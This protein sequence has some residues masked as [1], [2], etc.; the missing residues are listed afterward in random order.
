MGKIVSMSKAKQLYEILKQELES[1]KY[2]IGDRLP[3]IRSMAEEYGVSTNTV[4]TALSILVNNGLVYIEEGNGAYV[5]VER[6]AIRVLGTLL[7]DFS[8]GLRVDVDILKAIQDYTPDRYCLSLMNTGNRYDVFC[9]GLRQLA[10]M[11][12]AGYLIVPPRQEPTAEERAEA[13]RLISTR[14]TVMINRTIEGVEADTYSMN[15]CKG[16]EKAFA[17]F[18]SI[19][20]HKTAI[21]LHDTEKFVNEELEA[22]RK[23]SDAYS[24][25]IRPEWLIEW[26]DDISQVSEKLSRIL[27]Q[28]D[29][30]IGPDNLLISLSDQICACGKEIPTELSLVAINDTLYSRM[31]YPP[32]TSIVFPSE[33]IGRHAV[34]KLLQRIQGVEKGPYKFVN[35]E[36]EFVIRGT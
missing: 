13:I 36:P 12:A 3:S 26:N 16:I 1:G 29:S 14:P 11:G 30:L 18:E 23:Y 17:Y 31:F 20:K 8:V 33:R 4:S 35:F 34:N 32:L 25:E 21:L 5:G 28:I 27:P 24:L 7:F 19:G 9:H 15:L 6:N 10:E 22:C 2:N